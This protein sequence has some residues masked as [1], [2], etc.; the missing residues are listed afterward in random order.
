MEFKR[1]TRGR[2]I[3]LQII[4]LLEWDV[5]DTSRSESYGESHGNCLNSFSLV[6]NNIET[7][8]QS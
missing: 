2:F 3:L 5:L 7:K 6:L 8:S 4:C 1:E